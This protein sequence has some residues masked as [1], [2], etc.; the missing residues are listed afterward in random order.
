MTGDDK[1]PVR[2]WTRHPSRNR[3][4]LDGRLLTGGDAPWAFIASLTVLFAITGVYF[5]TTA[6][7]WWNNESIAVPIV[8]AYMTLLTISGML[9]TVRH[10][11][12]NTELTGSDP[13]LVGIHRSRHPSPQP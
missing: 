2:N 11:S 13:Q 1:Q 4:F 6:V 7:W 10:L 5:G 8:A 9:S 12:G 3:F